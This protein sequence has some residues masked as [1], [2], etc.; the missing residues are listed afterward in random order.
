M[1]LSR[2]RESGRI[3]RN[4]TLGM[5]R[6][7]WLVAA[8]RSRLAHA[9]SATQRKRSMAFGRTP[10]PVEDEAGASL[11]AGSAADE[12]AHAEHA[13]TN[14]ANPAAQIQACAV[15]ENH[16]SNRNGYETSASIEPR[17]ESANR[18]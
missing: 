3:Q 9:G 11:S 4:G 6:Q 7:S 13:T 17:F 15:R 10:R 2:E 1:K 14:A 18:R 16:G 8:S 12:S 5:P